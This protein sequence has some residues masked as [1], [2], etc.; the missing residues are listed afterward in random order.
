MLVRVAHAE[1]QPALFLPPVQAGGHVEHHR[2]GVALEGRV[3]LRDRDLVADRAGGYVHAGELPD[4]SEA[5]PTR[6]QDPLGADHAVRRLDPGDPRATPARRPE[7]ESQE[8]RPLSELDS[9]ALHGQRIREN[10]A[11]RIDA[12]VRGQEAPAAMTVRGQGRVD[13]DRLVGLQ[14]PHVK[15]E[16]PLHGYPLAPRS[17]LAAGRRQ[18]D[19]AELPESGVDPQGLGLR[20]V[21]LDG[22][23]AQVHG[24]RRS[25]LGPNDA[26]GTTAG[27]LPDQPALQDHD[28]PGTGRPGEDRGP[29]AQRP[30]ADHDEIGDLR[31]AHRPLRARPCTRSSL[32]SGP[33]DR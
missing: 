15:T 31:R 17:L 32:A 33:P 14:P 19:V 3:W 27:T 28:P 24:D 9:G 8:R 23:P 18:E 13:L 2:K 25:A 22:P 20:A 1:Q 26:G 4:R 21:E 16:G 10:V 7:P 5:G 11:R 30:G 29:A 12:P 6:Q